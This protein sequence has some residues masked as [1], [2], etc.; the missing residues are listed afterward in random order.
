VVRGRG[1]PEA[2][3]AGRVPR[4]ATILP[5]RALLHRQWCGESQQP[6]RKLAPK[7]RCA[8]RGRSAGHRLVRAVADRVRSVG[9]DAGAKA[10][11]T[12][13]P[14][15]HG[16][17]V[18]A[19]PLGAGVQN[20]RLPP[21]GLAVGARVSHESRLGPSTIRLSAQPRGSQHE[22]APGPAPSRVTRMRRSR[23]WPAPASPRVRNPLPGR[24]QL[25]HQIMAGR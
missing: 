22:R 9:P 2:S 11:N 7:H 16:P 5:I 20:R 24:H 10:L 13:V 12:E 23:N 8:A 3:G 19:A 14:V 15:E 1:I 18:A 21:M 4:R 17:R 25:A 6:C